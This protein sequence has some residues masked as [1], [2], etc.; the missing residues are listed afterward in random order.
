[1][2]KYI[3]LKQIRIDMVAHSNNIHVHV[4]F[5]GVIYISVIGERANLV[6]PMARFFYIRLHRASAHGSVLRA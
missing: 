1:M 3:M 6:I 4:L 5:C 2:H